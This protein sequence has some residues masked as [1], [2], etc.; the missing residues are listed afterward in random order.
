MGYVGTDPATGILRV[1]ANSL[2]SGSDM[3]D[4]AYPLR[5]AVTFLIIAIASVEC[6]PHDDLLN[7]AR[8]Q[9]AAPASGT[10]VTGLF[11]AHAE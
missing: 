9:E 10:A 2:R 4:Q 7:Q 8:A 5:F 1:W 3:T 6:V 11:D